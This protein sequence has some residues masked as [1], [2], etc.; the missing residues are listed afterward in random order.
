MKALSF[1]ERLIADYPVVPRKGPD[2]S[3]CWIQGV[4]MKLTSLGR[5]Q[6]LVASTVFWISAGATCHG[7][8]VFPGLSSATFGRAIP[9]A[10]IAARYLTLPFLQAIV[11][12][13]AVTFTGIIVVSLL[14]MMITATLLA[15]G[16]MGRKRVAAT[17]VKLS[18]ACSHALRSTASISCIL[19]VLE[20]SAVAFYPSLRVWFFY[21]VPL[22]CTMLLI[23]ATNFSIIRKEE[24]LRLEIALSE[25]SYHM[26]FE[27]SLLG[28]YKATL[29]GRILDCNFSFCQIFGYSSR[30][31]VI[32][33]SVTVGYF[34]AAERD[35]FNSW[36]QAN[37]HL[38]N[39]EQCLRRKDGR[40]A[41]ILNT[42]T[43]GRS[44]ADK[45]PV[46]KGTMLDISEL[47]MEL[48]KW[49]RQ[50]ARVLVAVRWSLSAA[51]QL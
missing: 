50:M 17:A 10:A 13:S 34:N 2:C 27:R 40:T 6:W 30:E 3:L 16:V 4:Q 38:T 43:L 49:L 28:T 14:V 46:I 22:L 24:Q 26:L 18:F 25:G 35:E 8:R 19:S 1:F 7:E 42:A 21:A 29:D 36:L 23:A 44:E 15:R 31:E 39:F 33:S 51:D 47:R 5:L 12:I 9:A 32:G 20:L 11:L 45:E 41:W 48:P 37:M